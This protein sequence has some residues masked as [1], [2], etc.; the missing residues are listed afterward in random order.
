MAENT[1]NIL[2]ANKAPPM[3]AIPTPLPS[4]RYGEKNAPI[5]AMEVQIEWPVAR[6]F[7]G[8]SSDVATHVTDDAANTDTNVNSQ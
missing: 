5:W 4:T 1:A 6:I 7:V 3:A 2:T 8:Y